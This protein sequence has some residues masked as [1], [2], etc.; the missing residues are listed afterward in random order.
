MAGIPKMS[1]INDPRL[2]EDRTL[3]PVF[4]DDEDEDDEDFD[5]DDDEVED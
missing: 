3:L 4:E 2:N 1:E 5:D